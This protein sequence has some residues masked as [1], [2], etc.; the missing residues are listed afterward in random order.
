MNLRTPIL[1]LALIMA[2]KVWAY[3]TKVLVTG[4][5]IPN[6]LSN[7]GVE[8]HLGAQLN[9]DLPFTD[10]SG[11]AVPLRS[12]FRNGK[13]VLMAM[14]YYTC[15][16]L[17]NYHLNGWT[18]AL[19]ELRWTSGQDFEVVAVSMNSKETPE[20][21]GK[22]KLNYLKVY[23][24]HT[25]D[26]GWHFLV[27]N[28]ANVHALATQ[29]GFKFRWMEDK[30]QFAHAS[31]AYV[32]TPEGKISR[33]LHGIEI[34]PNTLKLSLLEASNG[35]IGSVLEHAVMFCFQFD[36]VK[37]KYTL[38]AWNIMRIGAFLMMLLLAIFLIPVWWRE[39]LQQR[40]T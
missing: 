12:F 17:C 13:P 19:K 33:Y 16:A 39:Q 29:L 14:V 21:A 34:E 25:G 8:E 22:K 4:H 31:V 38:Y 23:D 3:D 26:P 30:Q 18:E 37:N 32:V 15:P 7:V 36:P 10:E 27:G 6:E 35:T 9:L 24:R 5:E 1:A 20:V 28:D 40:K 2:P 11:Q